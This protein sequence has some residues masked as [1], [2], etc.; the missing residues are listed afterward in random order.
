MFKN[1]LDNKRYYTL[2]YFY[3]NYF[4]EKAVKIS[5]NGNFTCPN[6]DGTVGFGGC[7][8][9][10]NGSGDFAGNKN[11]S[12]TEQFDEIKN[13]M[14]NKWD[15]SKFIAYFQAGT[16]TYAPIEKLK[17]KF[18]EALKIENV[19]GLAIST[20][21]DSIS[22]E[23]YKYL[24]ELNKRTFLTVELGLQTTNEKT[25]KLINRCHTVENFDECVLRLKEL[26]IKV[27]V[28]I[29]NGLPYETKD[30]MLTTVKHVNSLNVWGV[31]IHMLHII[32]DTPI[33][34]LYL[35]ENFHVLTRDEYVD[36][37]IS[38]LELLNENVVICRITGDANKDELV[39][40][41]W[42]LK[43]FVILNEIDKAMKLNNTYQGKKLTSQ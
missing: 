23:T 6:I 3:K 5:L 1:T 30:D 19:V 31:K 36:I 41:F 11:T 42:T 35:K 15:S 27:V 29:I 33:H 14:Q 38:Q 39:A 32:E 8:Y 28:H 12:I 2:N 10:K 4:G 20:R 25:S 26:N 17:S 34:K 18:E 7:I 22:E 13:K 9:C 37:V 24:D 43:K 16:N 21:S 40:P